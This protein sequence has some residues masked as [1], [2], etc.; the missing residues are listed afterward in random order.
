MGS[1]ALPNYTVNPPQIQNP[2][3][4]YGQMLQ[5][6]NLMGAQQM[7]PYQMEQEQAAAEKARNDVVMQRLTMQGQQSMINAVTSGKL[8]QFFGASAANAEQNGGFDGQGAYLALV[9]GGALPEQAQQ[10]ITGMQNYAKNASEIRKNGAEADLNF[11]KIHA[12]A[13]AQFADDI[14]DVLNLPA[15]QQAPALQLMQQRYRNNPPPGIDRDDLAL[16][17]QTDPS[18]LELM[19]SVLGLRGKMEEYQAG[20]AEKAGQGAQ[21]KQQ[22]ILA[23]LPTADQLTTQIGVVNKLSAIPADMRQALTVQMQNARTYGA[24]Q[25]IAKRADSFNESFQ[26]SVDA[27]QQAMALKDVGIQELVAGK[28]VAEDQAMAKN[29]AET[30]TIRGLLDMSKNGNQQAS[31]AAQQMF[32]EHIVRQ[33]GINRFN[34]LEQRGLVGGMGSWSRQFQGWLAKGAQGQMPT[35][36]NAE[37]SEILNAEDKMTQ[38]LHDE[39]VGFIQN[40]YANVG[41]G[42][43]IGNKTGA[44]LTQGNRP[45][46]W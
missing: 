35:A 43:A 15:N 14:Q 2:M 8:D 26:R 9:K 7:L 4:Q 16:F 39:N 28:T 24:L 44:K 41:K 32:A 17:Q 38:T 27:R 29:M 21:G 42:G 30:Q 31:A 12:D 45:P 23:A 33:G 25:D 13:H 5:L 34:E 20:L 18:H 19:S 1:I 10:W 40:R 37:M 11:L 36:T 22:Q 3:A 46:G 6:K